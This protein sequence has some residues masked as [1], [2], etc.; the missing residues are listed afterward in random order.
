[1]D[2]HFLGF[3]YG[4]RPGRSQP[5]ALDALSAGIVWKKVDWILDADIRSYFDSI[6]HDHLIQICN[7][8]S[9]TSGSF[10]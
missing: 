4:F 8:A 3:R 7:T 1:M 2:T 10:D 5:D 6:S 9:A